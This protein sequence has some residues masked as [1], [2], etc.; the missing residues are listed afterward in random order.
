LN[1]V[2]HFVPYFDGGD[3]KTIL[4]TPMFSWRS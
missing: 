4:A 1:L 3:E 2:A